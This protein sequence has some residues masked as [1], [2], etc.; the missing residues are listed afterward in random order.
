MSSSLSPSLGGKFLSCSSALVS[1]SKSAL[2]PILAKDFIPGCCTVA[3]NCSSTTESS[4]LLAL[5]SCCKPLLSSTF[6]DDIS[7]SVTFTPNL[8]HYLAG[9]VACPAAECSG[10]LACCQSKTALSLPG[11]FILP[12]KHLAKYGWEFISLGSNCFAVAEIK[13][14]PS[15]FLAHFSSDFTSSAFSF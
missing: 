7:Q 3:R 9:V 15:T 5:S 11:C 2:S 8:F 10:D 14:A 1:A 13:Q 6:N 12:V 4:L